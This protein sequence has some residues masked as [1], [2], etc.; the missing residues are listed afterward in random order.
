M[1]IAKGEIFDRSRTHNSTWRFW[2]KRISSYAN[3]MAYSLS[4]WVTGENKQ[5][6]Q[7]MIFNHLYV[8]LSEGS[9]FCGVHVNLNIKYFFQRRDDA[10]DSQKS[11]LYGLNIC[12]CV[13]KISL[14]TTR[15]KKT[16]GGG[17]EINLI[18]T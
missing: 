6:F 15:I 4:S 1:M 14:I 2:I 9:T 8:K 18:F 7:A 10:C 16:P 11:F 13:L 12:I 17:V 5:T 3:V